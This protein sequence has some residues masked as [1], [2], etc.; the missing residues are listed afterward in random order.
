[1]ASCGGRGRQLPG[2]SAGREPHRAHA[3]RVPRLA[4]RVL[5][6]LAGRRAAVLGRHSDEERR[7][8][9]RHDGSSADA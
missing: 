2:A 3:G 1:M 6:Q 7:P 9:E 5:L 8:G 4:A